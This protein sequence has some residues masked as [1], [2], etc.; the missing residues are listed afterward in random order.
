MDFTVCTR[1]TSWKKAMIS[2]LE[3]KALTWGFQCRKHHESSTSQGSTSQTSLTEMGQAEQV[4][5]CDLHMG[6]QLFMPSHWIDGQS[7]A[8]PPAVTPKPNPTFHLHL[9]PAL[10]AFLMCTWPAK[11][12]PAPQTH[13]DQRAATSISKKQAFPFSVGLKSTRGT[14]SD[15]V[16]HSKINVT[17]FLL[18]LLWE[19]PALFSMSPS[20]WVG[21]CVCLI[22]GTQ[23]CVLHSRAGC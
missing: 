4:K 12:Q 19:K 2:S 20:G 17:R 11:T 1:V 18:F 8:D 22:Y 23:I 21:K 10:T 14:P 15:L 3:I 13:T 16:F 6:P 7:C 9:A 5:R